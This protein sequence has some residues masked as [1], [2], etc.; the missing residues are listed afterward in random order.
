MATPKPGEIRCPT[1][2]RSTPPASFCTQCG[3][4]IP[5]DARIRPRGMDRD[6]LQD[7]IR[8]RRSGGDPYRRGGVAD[9]ERGG[10]ERYVPDPADA[11]ARRSRGGPSPRR[12]HFEEDAGEVAGPVAA[13]GAFGAGDLTRDRDEWAR[14]AAAAPP[15]MPPPSAEP[16]APPPSDVPVGEPDSPFYAD[17][18]E[19]PAYTDNFDDDAV[20]DTAYPYPYEDWEER[21]ERRTGT[22]ALAILGFLGLGVLALLAGAVLAGI[23]DGEPSTGL[24][25]ATPSPTAT[26]AATVEPTASPSIAAS[27]SPAATGS[28][29]ASGE[30]V[31]FPD[32]FT[33]EAQPCIRGSWTATGCN[34][35]GT[36]N[37]GA[38]DIWVG[39]TNGNSNDV[40]GATLVAPDGSTVDGSIDLAD[41]GCRRACNGYTYFPFDATDPGTYEVRVTRNGELA[42]TTTFEAS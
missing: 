39:F 12:D 4:A 23:F 14:P 7:R 6:E 42:A 11:S 3:S 41:I 20:D 17:S 5:S 19:Q 13:A 34:S 35:N 15:V 29:A 32:G 33:A 22:G 36:S 30:P 16:Y 40:I 25:D 10:Y 9:D 31:T 38:V 37:S 28:P 1:C 2:H 18:D 8:A 27:G 21:R 26:V 24:A